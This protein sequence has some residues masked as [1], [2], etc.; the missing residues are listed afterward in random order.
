VT[1]SSSGQ[2]ESFSHPVTADNPEFNLLCSVK[3]RNLRTQINIMENMLWFRTV[4]LLKRKCVAGLPDS[5][6]GL[7]TVMGSSH[8]QAVSVRVWKWFFN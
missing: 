8:G 3:I 5:S 4:S 6:V 7:L 2:A 1:G